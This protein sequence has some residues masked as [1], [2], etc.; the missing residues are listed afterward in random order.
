MV[1]P[2]E[3]LIEK[4]GVLGLDLTAEARAMLPDLRLLGG[5]MVA[6]SSARAI[7]VRGE[8]LLPGDVIHALNGRSV[9][10]LAGLRRVREP[11][12]PGDAVV[13][14]FGRAR[15]LL[16]VTLNSSKRAGRGGP[17]AN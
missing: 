17:R 1:R 9:T 14:Q 10:N 7:P 8:P 2:T 15:G 6:I 5:A 12:W 16:S 4:F 3:Q 13:L 11:L